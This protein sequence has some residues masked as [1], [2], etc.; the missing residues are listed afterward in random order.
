MVTFLKIRFEKN[1]IK[2]LPLDLLKRGENIVQNIFE[3]LLPEKSRKT[4]TFLIF[5]IFRKLEPIA[6]YGLAMF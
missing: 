5:V 6:S 1:G 4:V 3:F 2:N